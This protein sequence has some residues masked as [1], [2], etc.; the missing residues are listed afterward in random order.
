MLSRHSIGSSAMMPRQPSKNS[1]QDHLYSKRLASELKR[2]A[3]PRKIQSQTEPHVSLP[4][5]FAKSQGHHRSASPESLKRDL[6]DIHRRNSVHTKTKK[7]KK[8]HSKSVHPLYEQDVQLKLD[9][10]FPINALTSIAKNGHN[11]GSYTK[12]YLLL[13]KEHKR[14]EKYRVCPTKRDTTHQLACVNCSRRS[15]HF[16]KVFFPC[17][18]RCVCDKCLDGRMP[19]KCPLCNDAIRIVLNH[20]G[21]EHEEYW[22][23]VE[24]VGSL[25]SSR[26]PWFYLHLL[27]FC[28]DM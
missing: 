2:I 16:D 11:L 14:M 12:D 20:T 21:N 3:N 8:K 1:S 5:V 23:W 7:K 27:F 6:L 26:K 18:H 24:E 13:S 17:E 19:K 10:Q 25:L 22:K 4:S 15:R 28:S 9:E